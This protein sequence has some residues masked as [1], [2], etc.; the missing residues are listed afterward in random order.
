MFLKRHKCYNDYC[1][2]K[3]ACRFHFPR[4]LRVSSTININEKAWLQ[5]GKH[6]APVGSLRKVALNFISSTNDKWLNSYFPAGL[7]AWGGNMDFTILIDMD[8]IVQY[9]AKYGNKVEESSRGFQSILEMVNRKGRQEDSSGKTMLRSL[10][11]KLTGG[12]EMGMQET[13]HLSL[14]LPFVKSNLNFV[15]VNLLNTSRIIELSSTLTRQRRRRRNEDMIIDSNH[16]DND[17]AHT[18]LQL[19]ELI[20]FSIIDAYAD[21][22]N[23]LKWSSHSLFLSNQRSLQDLSLHNFCK[24]FYVPA[25]GAN[26]NRISLCHKKDIV[27]IYSPEIRIKSNCHLFYFYYLMK[28]LPW[29][30]FPQS[31]YNGIENSSITT[32]IEN[33]EIQQLLQ[34]KWNDTFSHLRVDQRPEHIPSIIN[35]IRF[36]DENEE[37]T[38]N[39]QS[40]PLER[41]DHN[42]NIKDS[43]FIDLCRSILLGFNDNTLQQYD[44]TTEWNSQHNWSIPDNNFYDLQ[45]TKTLFDNIW[46]N[47]LQ[48]HTGINIINND[49]NKRYRRH[50]NNNQIIAFDIIANAIDQRLNLPI[51]EKCFLLI[52]GAGCG[53][54]YVIDSLVTEFGEDKVII[55]AFSG[56]GN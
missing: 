41:M 20:K 49:R 8:A 26:K 6:G 35:D 30:N 36:N 31:L 38:P 50:L 18:N 34:Q 13:A 54:S 3:G 21:R 48:A 51:N 19:Q 11:T 47:I 10:F 32:D 5:N 45:L 37:W 40:D 22:M 56:F 44:G 28:H 42:E 2:A 17:A 55:T 15:S 29:F 46:Q 4:P 23:I 12:R 27:I 7:A 25:S 39:M 33:L 14:S 1:L 43:E 9:V 53:K 52:G 24:R 16:L